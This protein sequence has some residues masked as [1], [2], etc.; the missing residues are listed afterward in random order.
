[1]IHCRALTGADVFALIKMDL[2]KGPIAIFAYVH[3]PFARQMI[4]GFA[5]DVQDTERAE[6]FRCVLVREEFVLGRAIVD[7]ILFRLLRRHVSLVR[8]DYG[9]PTADHMPAGLADFSISH[10]HGLVV[11]A[12]TA[13]GRIGVD[14]ERGTLKDHEL[15]DQVLSRREQALL[16]AVPA[17]KRPHLFGGIWR[18]KEAVLKAKGVGLYGNPQEI[19]TLRQIDGR[20]CYEQRI[21][22]CQTWWHIDRMT[23]PAGDEIVVVTDRC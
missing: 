23:T 1:M 16:A 21:H 15:P 3:E 11:C 10:S 17:S 5:P 7:A 20:V 18:R 2:S 19:C 13:D 8:T 12:A 4:N 9:K 14:V 6:K 22:Y